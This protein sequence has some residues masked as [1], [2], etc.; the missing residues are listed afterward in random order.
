MLGRRPAVAG[1]DVK[2][3]DGSTGPGADRVPT[4]SHGGSPDLSSGQDASPVGS[5]DQEMFF[6]LVTYRLYPMPSWLSGCQSSDVHN[7]LVSWCPSAIPGMG[8][9]T[10]TR[11][12]RV[13][14]GRPA[15]ESSGFSRG[16]QASGR[17]L[18]RSLVAPARCAVPAHSAGSPRSPP[19]GRSGQEPTPRHQALG[20]PAPDAA[21]AASRVRFP[22]VR[23]PRA[24]QLTAH[25][26]QQSPVHS[27][28]SIEQG[29]RTQEGM[30][31]L[32][33]RCNAVRRGARAWRCASTRSKELEGRQ[34]GRAVAPGSFRPILMLVGCRPPGRKEHL[35]ATSNR[36]QQR[37]LRR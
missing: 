29:N 26:G 1:W 36:E 25:R 18:R 37:G 14:S 4:P 5:V 17:R 2:L 30:V 31:T 15:P 27:R 10:A 34:G 33:R 6:W 23:G 28:R 32:S 7:I 13:G 22:T 12:N 21:L 3:P 8:L 9:T 24:P 35:Q 19:Q 16:R 20:G 11:E